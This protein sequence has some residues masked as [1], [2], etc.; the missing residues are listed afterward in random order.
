[1]DK[2]QITTKKD[3]ARMQ[4][5]DLSIKDKSVKPPIWKTQQVELGNS[6]LGETNFVRKRMTRATPQRVKI[7]RT[8][9]VDFSMNLE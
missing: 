4:R 9:G 3:D 1:M 8:S 2:I 7:L 5:F 6:D